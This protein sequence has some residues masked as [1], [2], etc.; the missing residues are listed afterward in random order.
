M[1][2]KQKQA[3]DI[4]VAMLCLE[5]THLKGKDFNVLRPIL[6][7]IHFKRQTIEDSMQSEGFTEIRQICTTLL[8]LSKSI[9]SGPGTAPEKA[10]P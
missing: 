7:Q 9:L 8:D 5:T 2:H 1:L 10:S 6:I 3:L 4:I